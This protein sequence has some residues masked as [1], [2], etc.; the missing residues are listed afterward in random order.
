MD[1]DQLHSLCV[2]AEEKS[3]GGAARR[4]FITQPAISMQMKSLEKELGRILFDRSKKETCL[5]EEGKILFNH[6]QRVF[7]EI[8][9]ARNAIDELQK[10]IRGRLTI[11]CSDTVSSYLLPD[12][13]SGYIE[14]YPDIEIT[15]QNRPSPHIV[16]MVLDRV[17]DVG[18]VTLPVNDSHL[19]VRKLFAYRNVAVCSR[20]HPV[21]SCKKIPL[22][23]LIKHRLLL[24]DTGTKNRTLLDE[25]LSRVGLKP[26]SLMEF[27]SVEV[28]K[29]F[30]ETGIGVAV[31]PEFAVGKH[32]RKKGLMKVPVHKLG[33]NEFG[34]I[35]NKNRALSPAASEFVA[36]LESGVGEKTRT[37]KRNV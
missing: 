24:L 35:I 7:N 27:G 16:A 30:A 11:G 4:M 10:L 2:I 23:S 19:V 31:V 36:Q 33:R 20:E 9:H 21:A 22:S 13:I 26:R 8:E 25:A 32:D 29:S 1:L 3:F 34:I 6:A 5:T 28:Q 14:K 17:A 37:D 18:L 15:L 12:I